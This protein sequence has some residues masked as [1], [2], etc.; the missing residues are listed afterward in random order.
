M[1]TTLNCNV[2]L[3]RKSTNG[4]YK[5]FAI[6]SVEDIVKAETYSVKKSQDI[7]S[8]H[9][10]KVR[11]QRRS[12]FPNRTEQN[13]EEVSIMSEDGDKLADTSDNSKHRREMSG[14]AVTNE[15]QMTLSVKSKHCSASR[16]V[17]TNKN[18]NENIVS[19]VVP[20]KDVESEVMPVKDMELE[21]GSDQRSKDEDVS[22]SN[23][24]LL[25]T[26]NSTKSLLKR[27]RESPNDEEGNMNM[28]N[29]FLQKAKNAKQI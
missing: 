24:E 13:L 10:N 7:G 18:L 8:Q 6:E 19:E 29:E 4:H 25:A 9:P 1:T 11:V 17:N 3:F 21:Q 22:R 23:K 12:E 14:N 15:M 2:K 27:L 16:S 5:S 20:V 26:P 28:L